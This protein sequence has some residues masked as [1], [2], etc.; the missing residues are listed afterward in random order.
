MIRLLDVTAVE[1]QLESTLWITRAFVVG[2]GFPCA[3]ALI[4]PSSHALLTDD[5]IPIVDKINQSVP[6]QSRLARGSGSQRGTIIILN[7][8]DTF[9]LTNKGMINRTL[10][11]R[12]YRARIQEILGD[13]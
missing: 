5:L 8:D 6:A 11:E 13:R 9:E 10:T 3:G 2:T 7:P 1:T 4:I 12:K